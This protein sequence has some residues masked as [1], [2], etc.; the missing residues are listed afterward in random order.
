MKN[1][2][3]IDFKVVE[4]LDDKLVIKVTLNSGLYRFFIYIR[5]ANQNVATVN[6]PFYAQSFYQIIICQK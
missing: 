2:E 3:L 1:S 5:T 6:L 4:N